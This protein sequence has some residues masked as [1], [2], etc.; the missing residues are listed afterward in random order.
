MKVRLV[1]KIP[2]LDKTCVWQHLCRFWHL[3]SNGVLTRIVLLDR[4]LFF[5][6][7]TEEMSIYLKRWEKVQNIH[8]NHLYILKFAI[9]WR[10]WN[11]VA[12][13]MTLT[14]FLKVRNFNCCCLKRW[15]IEQK[16]VWVTNQSTFWT[17]SFFITTTISNLI[18][19]RKPRYLW[20]VFHHFAGLQINRKTV[21]FGLW[22]NQ[23][24]HHF[25]YQHS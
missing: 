14:Y 8:W 5:E 10:L 3:P 20:L 16:L 23:W 21:T 19:L 18:Q 24:I 9:K 2:D 25:R 11:I 13:S 22:A 6:D 4:Y 17:N 12:Y 15:D 1:L 7:Q